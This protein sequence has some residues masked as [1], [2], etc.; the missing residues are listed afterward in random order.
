MI[1]VGIIGAKGYAAGEALRLLLAHPEMQ[2]TCLMARVA[3]SEPVHQYFPALRGR[4]HLEIELID[5]DRVAS[6]CDAVIL[7]LPH[8]AAQEV[9]PALVE[10]GLKVIDLS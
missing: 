10:K 9:A 6:R 3:D 2:V 4:T 7:G 8:T 1:R 5:H